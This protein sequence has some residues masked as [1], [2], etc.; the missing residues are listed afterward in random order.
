MKPEDLPRLQ[1]LYE[2]GVLQSH[3]SEAETSE[4]NDMISLW[5]GD[6][7][8]LELDAIVNAANKTLMGG[9]GVDGAI[10]RKAGPE[11]KRECATLKGCQTGEAKITKG[12]NL[13]SKR[14]KSYNFGR[15]HSYC[16]PD[17]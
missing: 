1:S 2:S 10:H 17:W 7:T 8:I 11:L 3:D 12:Y 4:F 13:P 5:N 6:I 16:G 9:G 15:C 14:M